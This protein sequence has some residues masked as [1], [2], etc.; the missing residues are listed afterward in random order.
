MSKVAPA[1]SAEDPNA[2]PLSYES[3]LGEIEALVAQMESAQLPLEQ[4]LDAY[5][6]GAFLLKYCRDK[7]DAVE[8]QIKVLED[9]E[10]KP[11]KS[12]T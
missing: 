10:L 4:L 8:D 12:L 3:A 6:R 7:L 2:A 11:W 1:P 5:K 9:G